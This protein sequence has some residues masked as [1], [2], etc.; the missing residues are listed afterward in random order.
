MKQ[1]RHLRATGG[2]SCHWSF[3]ARATLVASMVAVAP[4]C[5][6]ECAV[7]AARAQDGS[8]EEEG[9]EGPSERTLTLC[10]CPNR[11][12]DKCCAGSKASPV[13]APAEV[14]ES[15]ESTEATEAAEAAEAGESAAACC[16]PARGGSEKRGSTWV[17]SLATGM[18]TSGC[19]LLQ[20]GLNL[21]PA[22]STS[23]CFGFNTHL[24]KLRPLFAAG[25]VLWFVRWAWRDFGAGRAPPASEEERRSRRAAVW[26]FVLTAAASLLISLSP[27]IIA[28][29]SR[30]RAAS[31]MLAAAEKIT[32]DV[33]DMGCEACSEA[34]GRAL[35][36]L[37]GAAG[38]VANFKDGT[39]TLFVKQG[40][41]GTMSA[42]AIQKALA[43]VGYRFGGI[44][45]A[46]RL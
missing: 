7:C 20:L 38:G 36:A 29:V 6:C 19:C 15:T 23:G 16:T 18:A 17:V 39:A 33:L 46:V 41:A 37:P 31:A 25:T 21:L 5:A 3:R 34:V 10:V 43:G 1:Q 11:T 44:A 27:E 8:A 35:R 22:F 14:T 40:A 9:G 13:G 2:R 30:R 4:N 45:S 24:K 12:E 32:I 42:D 26:R 28:F